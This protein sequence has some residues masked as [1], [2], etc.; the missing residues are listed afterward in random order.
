MNIYL[1]ERRP[2][3]SYDENIGHV[4]R[5]LSEKDARFLASEAAQREGKEVWGS[6]VV[7]VE[8]LAEDVNGDMC[9]LLTSALNG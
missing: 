3:R 9:I 7:D 6:D 5:A 8:L 2:P 4:I 1:L